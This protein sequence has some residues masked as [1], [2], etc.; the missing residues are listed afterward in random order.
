MTRDPLVVDPSRCWIRHIVR[1]DAG[2][3]VVRGAFAAR[4]LDNVNGRQGWQSA[5]VDLVLSDDGAWQV[6]FPNAVGEDGKLH[7]RRFAALTD[8]AYRPGEEWIEIYREPHDLIVVGT[9][10]RYTK[11]RTEVGLTGYDV[12]GLLA[13]FRASE[14]DVWEG[15]APRDVFEHYTRAPYLAFGSALTDWQLT[16]AGGTAGPWAYENL[17]QSP[18]GQPRLDG[19][20]AIASLRRAV[21]V[22]ETDCW[23]AEA[24]LTWVDAAPD[25]GDFVDLEVTGTGIVA[26]VYPATGDVTLTGTLRGTAIGRRVGLTVPGDVTLR[27]VTRYDRVFVLLGGQLI[28]EGRRAGPW[29]AP[30]RLAVRASGGRA[31]LSA[32]SLESLAPFAL[33][34]AD[35]G[36]RHLPG[37][38]PRGGLRVRVWNAAPQRAAAAGDAFR[39][40]L[41]PL[42]DEPATDDL[43]PTLDHAAGALW[44]PG[45][46]DAYVARWTG[47]VYLDLEASDY[48][49]RLADAQGAAR[50]Y[51]GRSLPGDEAVDH[52]TDGVAADLRTPALR[53]WLG[54]SVSG[55]Y[56]IR[57]EFAREAAGAGIVLERVAVDV[58]GDP[59]GAW[60]VVPAVDLTPLGTYDDHVRGEAHREIIRSITE[61]FG[62]QWATE[63]RSLESG[64]FPGQLIPRVRAGVDRDVTIDSLNGSSPEVE[65]D[66]GDTIDTL[67]AD[68]AGI[69]DPSGSG[70][71]TAQVWD[72]DAALAHIAAHADAESLSEITEA[73]MLIRRIAS[74]LGL[75]SSP[76]EQVGVRPT[77]SRTLADTFPLTGAPARMRWRPGDG[78]RLKL[79]DVDV[80]DRTPR[81]LTK[82]SWPFFP[83]G[84]G[85]PTVGFRQR[86]RSPAAVLRRIMRMV[87][88]RGRNYQG[89][90]TLVDGA[91]GSSSGA[92]APDGYSRATAPVRIEDV[93][94]VFAHVRSISGSWTLE[95]S[96]TDTGLE[97]TTPGR[98]DVTRW[99]APSESQFAARLID[100][101]GVSASYD[102]TL[103]VLVRI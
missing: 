33:R 34:G 47:A 26:R 44:P 55:W 24:R 87:V 98:Y 65:G 94:R 93:V 4:P 73:P 57:V 103:Q 89:T 92:R 27:V 81:Q 90:L 10:V 99:A 53:D 39:G 46:P 49:L 95:V 17:A 35:R 69:A 15:A 78:V 62:Y 88:S 30:M 61:T 13:R 91:P 29:G 36:D 9:P 51:V 2:V 11:S 25:A 74:L 56:P 21:A 31:D 85:A 83:D 7:R 23:I 48:R 28:V 79:D 96:G 52:W 66:A 43:D 70:Q 64:E 86:P 75:R 102:L 5:G 82:V 41:W 37:I 8:P 38:P 22:D 67:L 32:L 6:R 60:A 19:S 80:R 59:T 40:A 50:V 71:L 45:V 1:D 14:L 42:D 3:P 76:N 97:V 72:Y 101:A 12:A 54:Q 58:D 68:A 63:P 20:G 84:V 100:G 77:G 16:G 18:A